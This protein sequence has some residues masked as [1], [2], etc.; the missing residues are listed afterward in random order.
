MKRFCCL[1]LTVL[2]LAGCAPMHPIADT[3]PPLVT[4]APTTEAAAQPATQPAVQPAAIIPDTEPRQFFVEVFREGERSQIP[5]EIVQ[6][7]VGSY[8]IAMDPEYFTFHPQETVDLFSYDAWTEGPGVFYAVS[9]YRDD[10]DLLQFVAD[11]TNQYAPLFTSCSTQEIT[12][13]GFPATAIYLESFLLDAD[14][15]YHIFLVNCQGNYYLIEASFTMEMYEG[16]Y[17]IMQACFET[18]A[19]VE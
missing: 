18:M 14:Y 6:G 15:Q 17:A 2:F 8:T 3:A 19:P 4:E 10:V 9:D 5:V 1:I 16:L 12:L 7:T 11:T 13:A